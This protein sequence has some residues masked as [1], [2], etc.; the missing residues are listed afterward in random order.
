MLLLTLTWGHCTPADTPTSPCTTA[1]SNEHQVDDIA[2]ASYVSR[3]GGADPLASNKNVA[4][5][6]AAAFLHQSCPVAVL[7][8]QVV[9]GTG[10]V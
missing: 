1:I 6:G 5:G 9:G 4:R 2:C 8:C 10:I 3:Q 7:D